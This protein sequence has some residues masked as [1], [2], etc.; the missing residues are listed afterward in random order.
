MNGFSE[1]SPPVGSGDTPQLY[2]L[3]GLKFQALCRD[4]LD[5]GG[6]PQISACREYGTPG[7][8]QHGVDLIADRKDGGTDVVQCKCE[9]DFPPAKIREASSEFLQH[10][11]FWRSRDVRRFILLV[12]SEVDQTQRHAEI[13]KQTLAFRDHYGISYELWPSISIVNKLRKHRGIVSQHLNPGWAEILCGSTTP[14]S[15]RVELAKQIALADHLILALTEA[16]DERLATMRD[17]WRKGHRRDARRILTL[18]KSDQVTW[19]ALSPKVQAGFLRFEA[20]IVLEAESDP[21]RA[22]DLLKEAHSLHPVL[23]D[24]RLRAAILWHRGETDSALDALDVTDTDALRHFKAFLLITMRRVEDAERLLNQI[25]EETGETFQLRGLCSLAGRR[26]G[27]ARL[28]LQKALERSPGWV[29]LQYTAAAIDYFGALAPVAIP[30]FIPQWPEPVPTVYALQDDEARERLK[31]AAE[32][33]H[34]I[35]ASAELEE[36][37]RLC[38]ETWQ[39]ACLAIDLERQ[40][41]FE[42][43]VAL[44]LKSNPTHHRVLAWAA[45]AR[46]ERLI[47]APAEAIRQLVIDGKADPEQILVLAQYYVIRNKP[48]KA[49]TLLNSH[50]DLFAA[51]RALAVWAIWAAQIEARLGRTEKA[52]RL[53]DGAG[54]EENESRLLASRV[55]LL[56]RTNDPDRVRQHLEESYRVTGDPRFLLDWVEMSAQAKAW[57]SAADRGRELFQQ[58]PTPEVLRLVAFCAH[59]AKRYSLCLEILNDTRSPFTGAR[60]PTELR[61]MKVHCQ[62]EL[63][64]LPAAVNEAERLAREEP[65]LHNLMGLT[66][67]YLSIGDFRRLCVTAH[68]I[69]RVD[70]VP[71]HV[72]LRLAGQTRWE[73]KPL[74]GSLWRRAVKIGLSDEHVAGAVQLGFELGFDSELDD[75]ISRMADLGRS[76]QGGVRMASLDDLRAH[77]QAFQRQAQELNVA[78]QEAQLPI[79]LIAPRLNLTLAE[80]YHKYFDDN[81]RAQFLW[82]QPCIFVRSGRRALGKLTE[83]ETG[84]F[85]LSADITAILFAYHFGFLDAVE[86]EFAPIRIPQELIPT[87][88]AMRDR[89]TAGQAQ[90]ILSHG[91]ILSAQQ[92]GRIVVAPDHVASRTDLPTPLR[93]GWSSFAELA[94]QDGGFV[95]DFIPLVTSVRPVQLEELPPDMRERV[96]GLRAV[97][98]GLKEGGVLTSDRYRLILDRQI[99]INSE[100][101]TPSPPPGT[102]LYF[103]GSVIQTFADL[104]LIDALTRQFKVFIERQES[105]RLQEEVRGFERR[106]VLARWVADLITH[107]NEGIQIGHYEAISS[108]K[109]VSVDGQDLQ[110]DDEDDRLG[111]RCLLS[112]VRLRGDSKDRV[113]VDDRFVNSHPLAGQTAVIDSLELLQQLVLRG[114]VSAE[115]YYETL[116]RMRAEGV[117]FIPLCRDEILTQLQL[118]KIEEDDVGETTGLRDLRRGLA[119]SLLCSRFLR[120]ARMDGQSF[121]PGEHQFLVSSISAVSEA[122]I[123]LWMRSDIAANERVIKA[124]WILRKLLIPHHALR[125]IAGIQPESNDNY[126]FATAAAS[127]LTRTVGFTS[128]DGG[129][130]AARDFNSWV[131]RRLLERRFAVEP[132]LLG[133]TAACLQTIIGEIWPKDLAKEESR[134]AAA[135]MQRHFLRLPEQIRNSI[136]PNSDFLAKMGVRTEGRVEVAGLQ[137]ERI[138]YLTAAREAINGREAVARLIGRDGNIR[139]SPTIS[140]GQG[141]EFHHPDLNRQIVVDDWLHRLLED[142]P[143]RRESI[144]VEIQEMLDVPAKASRA[145]LSDLA[146]TEDCVRRIEKGEALREKSLPYFYQQLEKKIRGCSTLARRDLFPDDLDALPQYLRLDNS[147]AADFADALLHAVDDMVEGLSLAEAADRLFRVP[148][149]LPEPVR[150]R[151]RS[152]PTEEK[153]EL[154]CTLLGKRNSPLWR[155]QFEEMLRSCFSEEEC[156]VSVWNVHPSAAEAELR[157]YLVLIQWTFD[158]LVTKQA[159]SHWSATTILAT[160][161]AHGDRLFCLLRSHGWDVQ[162][163]AE[164]FSLT[165]AHIHTLFG[166]SD[167][168]GRDVANPHNVT[169]VVLLACGS[170]LV[171]SSATVSHLEPHVKS[172]LRSLMV[173]NT[174]GSVLPQLDLIPDVTSAPNHLLSFLGCDRLSTFQALAEE[175]ERA[176]LATFR[177]TMQRNAVTLLGAGGKDGWTVLKAAFGNEPIPDDYIEE[178]RAALCRTEFARLI[179]DGSDTACKF[180]LFASTFLKFVANS[181]TIARFRQ[182]LLQLADALRQAPDDAITSSGLLLDAALNLARCES[183]PSARVAEFANT[184]AGL[185]SA[186]PR[187]GEAVRPT[188]ER[189]CDDL[190]LSQTAEM[191]RL[192]LRLRSE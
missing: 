178:V 75:L 129:D 186:W 38:L 66:Q 44:L 187:L 83:I 112:L 92:L 27:E 35:A 105:Q 100:P 120:P 177:A 47:A 11:D 33:F 90:R 84:E 130:E 192:N 116:S 144:V 121:D 153:R 152:L 159:S 131:Y 109:L 169:P 28:S 23:D 160:A 149:E 45:V 126:A 22:E 7:Q 86:R 182:H 189:M 93:D 61:Q 76:A 124:N 140:V 41:L 71:S 20:S 157:A 135:I 170:R 39:V 77:A 63:G 12:G 123:A 10:L 114:S 16:T 37:E 72:L 25:S 190:P 57:S 162:T 51:K 30:R 183:T 143:A 9:R 125:K 50:R 110:L 155:M 102:K 188:I 4:L 64:L 48:Q 111:L 166:D 165:P 191:W 154:A 132:T 17:S 88:A 54:L 103:S 99:P 173:L 115:R 89:L 151:I 91:K 31:R 42:K 150:A 128:S 176:T 15:V 179:T 70:Q 79:H 107:L 43:E 87:L 161:W 133:Q 137:F 180:L 95:V 8:R 60:M 163:I 139:L 58:I 74:A 18:T 5:S 24:T 184:V 67:A 134:V 119:A 101:E 1:V 117:C 46:L 146:S 185:V 73:D 172:R 147:G 96:I 171:R 158:E 156:F 56:G 82:H 80:I 55:L 97:L 40:D 21:D 36:N 106:E 136:G 2:R 26:I 145:L 174:G 69:L 81:S 98:V 53:I 142:S 49:V 85:G 34:R 167:P 138:D 59:E 175:E 52:L 32:G 113:W 108:E 3:P 62:I 148:V 6:D 181:E 14:S 168:L 104:D 19:N 94:L 118:A 68:E 164:D 78:Y 127:L 122:L 65:S 29:S 13:L 141:F